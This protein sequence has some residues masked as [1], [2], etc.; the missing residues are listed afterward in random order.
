M[1]AIEG[2]KGREEGRR[3]ESRINKRNNKI[4]EDGVVTKAELKQQRKKLNDSDN[5][6]E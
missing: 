3:K 4:L 2:K 6:R 5:S 1:K